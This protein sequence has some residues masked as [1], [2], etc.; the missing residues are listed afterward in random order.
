M[1]QQGATLCNS[2]S[3]RFILQVTG[4]EQSTPS[5]LVER[6]WR[7]LR[8]PV[9]K[10]SLLTPKTESKSGPGPRNQEQIHRECPTKFLFL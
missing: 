3:V 4:S 8:Y 10:Q 7:V 9:V 1:T 2:Q 6:S 5:S